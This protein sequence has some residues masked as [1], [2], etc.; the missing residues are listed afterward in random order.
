MIQFIICLL[1][2]FVGCGEAL[3]KAHASHKAIRQQK[4]QKKQQVAAAGDQNE[5]QPLAL[6]RFEVHP[7]LRANH[8]IFEFN[9]AFFSQVD[10]AALARGECEI[11]FP[12]MD[13]KAF[14]KK[15]IEHSIARLKCTNSKTGKA[16]TIIKHVE[17]SAQKLPIPSVRLK[18]ILKPNMVNVMIRRME[19]PNRCEIDFFS[20]DA[21]RKI[22]EGKLLQLAHNDRQAR[23]SRRC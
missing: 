9:K 12:G 16:E 21:L 7:L 1:F 2:L 20:I 23:P 10:E 22:E 15:E 8:V 13:I 17:L 11:L 3:P 19:G 14:N 4:A 5:D 18:I 6:T